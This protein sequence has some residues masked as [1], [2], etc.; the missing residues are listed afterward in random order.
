MHKVADAIEAAINIPFLH[1]ADA[2]AGKIREA[3][4]RRPAIMA[5]RFTME[6]DFYTGRLREKFGLDAITPDADD[7]TLVHK[8]IYDELC[9]GRV[10]ETSRAAYVEVARRLAEKGADCLVLGC[11]EVGMLLN[12]GNAPLPI[13]DTTLIHADAAVNFALGGNPSA[14][15]AE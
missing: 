2:T 11:T 12:E 7:R 3:G 10:N 8:I 5:T 9:V 6:Q 4:K 1:I 13:F 15:A 14:Q